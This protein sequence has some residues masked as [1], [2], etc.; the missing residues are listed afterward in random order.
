MKKLIFG[1][2]FLTTLTMFSQESGEINFD[3]GVN[4]YDSFDDV[5]LVSNQV[6][7]FI[8]I[9]FDDYQNCTVYLFDVQGKRIFKQ[10]VEDEMEVSYSVANLEAGTY[11]LFI[12]DRNNKKAT[13]FRV[14][15]L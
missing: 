13:N 1:L 11:L 7:D 2:L 3:F 9:E 5:H 15:K 4:L 8:T 12:I 10:K 6:S 14:K